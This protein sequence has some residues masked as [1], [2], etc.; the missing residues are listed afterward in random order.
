[1]CVCDS[2]KEQVLTT[3]RSR[4][5]V[6]VGDSESETATHNR[7]RQREREREC[8][9]VCARVCVSETVQRECLYIDTH[10]TYERDVQIRKYLYCMY[11]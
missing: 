6:W 2:N 11:I 9:C 5:G 10:N 3:Q 7:E 8:A 4:G 1:M